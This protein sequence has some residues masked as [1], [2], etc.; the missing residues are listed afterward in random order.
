[1]SANAG[2]TAS[3]PHLPL[4]DTCLF[5][6]A[7]FFFDVLLQFDSLVLRARYCHLLS[8]KGFVIQSAMAAQKRRGQLQTLRANAPMQL[9]M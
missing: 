4:P 1:M 5:W 6:V 8:A 2:L 9:N 7:L 3:D